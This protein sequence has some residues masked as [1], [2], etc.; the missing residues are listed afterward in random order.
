[1]GGG[2]AGLSRLSPRV[3]REGSSHPF[4]LPLTPDPEQ[5]RGPRQIGPASWGLVWEAERGQRAPGG[6]KVTSTDGHGPS[7]AHSLRWGRS[8]GP[9]CHSGAGHTDPGIFVV[10]AEL[11]R[12]ARARAYLQR[13]RSP[14]SCQE[15]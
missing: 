6:A 8:G 3:W 7:G 4:T 15:S 12:V 2:W 5:G 14:Y 9:E 10:P 1:M 11:S 13:S